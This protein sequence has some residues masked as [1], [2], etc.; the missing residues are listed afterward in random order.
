MNPK[1]KMILDWS[2]SHWLIILFTIV[3]LSA[4]IVGWIFSSS[5]NESVVKDI[6]KRVVDFSKVE[7]LK[8]TKIEGDYFDR[9]PIQTL[10]NKDFITR[11]ESVANEVKSDVQLFE[12]YATRFNRNQNL[13]TGASSGTTI[14]VVK[15]FEKGGEK[16]VFPVFGNP[17]RRSALPG[18][19]REALLN[20]MINYYN[21]LYVEKS[22]QSGLVPLSEMVLE[23]LV[24]KAKAFLGR[25]AGRTMDEP[26]DNDQ[27]SK[28][29]DYL[30]KERIGLY[31]TRAEGAPFYLLFESLL[32]PVSNPQ[33]TEGELFVLQWKW[34]IIKEIVEAVR[35]INKGIVESAPVKQLISFEILDLPA[36]QEAAGGSK[37]GRG[38]RGGRGGSSKSSEDKKILAGK[39]DPG[40]L[41]PVD[42]KESLT[43]RV[44]NPLWDVIRVKV[45]LVAE[46]SKINEI[47]NGFA[48]QNFISVL[49]IN[50][51]SIDNFG[52][53]TQGYVYGAR[54]VTEVEFTLETVWLRSWTT[55]MM[56]DSIKRALKI[57]INK[58]S[59]MPGGGG[60]R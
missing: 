10:I 51:T 8:S 3:F 47:I 49:G 38:A 35:S 28:L 60:R 31:R 43:G 42:F 9:S 13:S 2:K 37:Q 56:P 30:S 45:K 55:E 44:S 32:P 16:Q 14:N 25:T 27:T 12:S 59:A 17:G 52:A 41:A 1:Q 6:N 46:T 7:K 21:G 11:Y 40:K 15:N 53:L 57:E 29:L 34:R 36:P 19:F 24:E 5:W 22:F 26:L 4:P 33:A 58:S 23:D 39:Y 50:M 18:E 20:E 54:P 48:K